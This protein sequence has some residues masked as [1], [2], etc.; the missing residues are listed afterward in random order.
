MVDKSSKGPAVIDHKTISMLTNEFENL[1]AEL[2]GGYIPKQGELRMC[3]ILE[4]LDQEREV[5]VKNDTRSLILLQRVQRAVG[6]MIAEGSG[7]LFHHGVLDKA[8]G[9]SPDPAQLGPAIRNGL[10]HLML[11]H[12]EQDRE[13][14]ALGFEAIRLGGVISGDVRL[15]SN[16][17]GLTNDKS[18]AFVPWRATS[19]QKRLGLV[20]EE[21]LSR[22]IRNTLEYSY[23]LEPRK[24]RA[25]LREMVSGLMYFGGEAGCRTA[26]EL[27]PVMVDQID[28]DSYENQEHQLQATDEVT[29]FLLDDFSHT[30]SSNTLYALREHNYQALLD[31]MQESKTSFD[32]G[33]A[34]KGDHF[35][36]DFTV[37]P[38]ESEAAR[39]IVVDNVNLVFCGNYEVGMERASRMLESLRHFGIRGEEL[40]LAATNSHISCQ[41]SMILDFCL[42]GLPAEDFLKVEPRDIVKEVIEF[43]ADAPALLDGFI[44]SNVRN[45]ESYTEFLEDKSSSVARNGLV[46]GKALKDSRIDSILSNPEAMTC[47]NACS[48]YRYGSDSNAAFGLPRESFSEL[49]IA[50]IAGFIKKQMDKEKTP[51][52]W[53]VK[54]EFQDGILDSLAQCADHPGTR[55]AMRFLS[56]EAI[57]H[58][59]F[60]FENW[61]TKDYQNSIQW[62]DHR[63]KGARLEDELGM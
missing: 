4:V 11:G 15:M 19:A 18:P 58:F 63:M 16:G 21:F 9:L 48:L 53:S 31:L 5:F 51:H 46:V 49:E 8:V 22:L 12:G 52:A 24:L 47:I 38:Y 27:L 59:K 50:G 44:T 37:M 42:S 10:F 2:L 34:I 17:Y 30:R 1:S 45:L 40:R 33:N 14:I 13:L 55:E 57:S 3:E 26:L 54:K 6:R 60:V 23:I 28:G 7:W 32:V 35:D 36:F 56:P 41:L 25:N 43:G 20:A 39:K 62:I 61:F 29:R